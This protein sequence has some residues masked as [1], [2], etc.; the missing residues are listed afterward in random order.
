MD[1]IHEPMRDTVCP[2]QKIRKFRC[3]MRT[4]NGFSLRVEGKGQRAEAEG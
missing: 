3:V 4:R 2:N 1:C